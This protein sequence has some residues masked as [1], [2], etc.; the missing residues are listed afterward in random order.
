MRGWMTAAV[1]A[2]AVWLTGCGC[3]G[4]LPSGA[5]F[6]TLRAGCGADAA[7]TDYGADAQSVYSTLFD[8]YV[9][10]RHRR[11]SQADYCAFESDIASHYRG[12]AAGGPDAQ[13]AWAGYFNAQR[14]KAIDWRAQVDPTLR[15]G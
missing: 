10:Y 6:A 14:V 13:A 9:A 1:C 3:A 8:A 15:G 12:R 4:V 11:L 5:S 7:G 2:G